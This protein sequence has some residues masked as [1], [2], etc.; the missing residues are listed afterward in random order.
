MTSFSCSSSFSVVCMAWSHRYVWDLCKLLCL[1]FSFLE[2]YSK[3]LICL[4]L[5][6]IDIRLFG[7]RRQFSFRA[8]QFVSSRHC[9]PALWQRITLSLPHFIAW[10]FLTMLQRALPVTPRM[11]EQ[12]SIFDLLSTMFEE[13]RCGTRQIFQKIFSHNTYVVYFAAS[14]HSSFHLVY[15]L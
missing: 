1:R 15:T 4:Q 9:L 12:R 6:E 5:N 13:F 8:A 14:A 11:R 10:Q 7:A 2:K 3:I